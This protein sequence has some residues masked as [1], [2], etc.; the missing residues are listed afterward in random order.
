[1]GSSLLPG[2]GVVLGGL[3]GGPIGALAG[4]VGGLI[5]SFFGV[6]S[7]PQSISPDDA[8]FD[9]IHQGFIDGVPLCGHDYNFADM[10]GGIKTIINIP[11]SDPILGGMNRSDLEKWL[12]QVGFTTAMAALLRFAIVPTSGGVTTESGGGGEG[13]ITV[14]V[15]NAFSISQAAVAAITGSI[16]DAISNSAATTAKM[17]NGLFGGIGDFFKNLAGTL[18]DGLKSVLSNIG[19]VLQ[20]IFNNI[21]SILKDV[22]SKLASDIFGILKQIGE[23][24]YNA[25]KDIPDI[26]HSI[27][28]QIQK[29]NDT[30][31]TPIVTFYN[32]TVRTIATLTV[33]IEN[34]LHEGLQ[35]ILKIPGDIAQGLTSLDATLQRTV[36]Q[37][38]IKNKEVSVST[39]DYEGTKLPPLYASAGLAAYGGSP[40]KDKIAST[41]GETDHLNTESLQ[42]ISGQ[43]I[44]AL[45]SLLEDILNMTGGMTKDAFNK[46]HADWTSIGSV[47]VALLDGLLSIVVTAASA[48]A[49]AE[50]LVEAAVEEAH[51]RVPITK[52]DIGTVQQAYQRQFLDEKTTDEELRTKGIDAT[53]SQVLKDLTKYL[54]DIGQAVDWW[55]R[56]LIPDDDLANNLKQHGV[57]D[58]DI[59][60]LKTGAQQ[61]APQNFIERWLNFGIITQD[62]ATALLKQLRWTDAMIQG[63]TETRLQRISTQS[64]SQLDGRLNAAEAGW[65]NNTFLTPT[66]QSVVDAAQREGL[67]PDDA[68]LIWQNHWTLPSYLSIIQS[69][70]RGMRTYTEVGYMMQ[71]QN[72]PHE[73][74][75]ELIQIMRPLIPFRSIPSF[76]KAGIMTEAQGRTELEQ[77]GFDPLRADI[78]M[79]YATISKQPTAATAA[80]QIHALSIQNARQLFDDGVLAE[81]DYV[82]I[83]QAHGYSLELAQ[84][85][86]NVDQIAA[87]AKQRKQ[88]MADLEAQ[89]IAGTL[90][91]NDALTQLSTDGFTAAEIARFSNTVNRALVKNIKQ[92]S[93]SDLKTFFKA[94]L[95]DLQTFKDAM[96]NLGWQ[97]P[98]LTAFLGLEATPDE[99]AALQ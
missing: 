41:F 73:L 17:V 76:V 87:H 48:T 53:R 43:A 84:A 35:G 81:S 62:Q 66:P 85:Q 68:R 1:M 3:I 90:Q 44:S 50:P 5:G 16:Q 78:I 30:L 40:A 95:I 39:V 70:F 12:K 94:K 80:Q 2:G 72:V 25:V 47:F 54:A 69:Y 9:F 86:A 15:N 20:Q 65:L 60:L 46:L 89:V 10:N 8:L 31:I 82:T 61:L 51:K 79:R 45:G 71:A 14:V 67:H 88:E 96:V 26:L 49:L 21:G 59:E 24:I 74:W 75:D 11:C 63:W 64:R 42:E 4:L 91:P 58:R 37:L 83:L 27:S 28:T 36:E 6:N 19:G 98:W 33:A 57:I 52:L 13:P 93:Y 38:G 23:F 18:L 55:F 34:D 99:I 32:S 77:H 22:F 92:P 7:G 97:D 56:G 29:I